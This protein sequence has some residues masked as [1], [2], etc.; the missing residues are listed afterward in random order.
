MGWLEFV[1][2]NF[3]DREFTEFTAW[4]IG[5]IDLDLV[6]P[7]RVMLLST[8]PLFIQENFHELPFK[9]LHFWESENILLWQCNF[10]SFWSDWFDQ[11]FME[12]HLLKCTKV[13][14]TII[15]Y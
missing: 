2:L 8:F 10:C 7:E 4:E 11:R 1:E 15:S 9:D 12:L 14:H 13:N 6:Y 5:E 3:P